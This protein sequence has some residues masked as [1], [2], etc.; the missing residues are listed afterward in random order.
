[1]C[2]V[3]TEPDAE[4]EDSEVF[5]K[6]VRKLI[7]KV[8]NNSVSGLCHELVNQ[9]KEL[10]NEFD[11]V[12]EENE[13]LRKEN[14]NL[15]EDTKFLIERNNELDFELEAQTVATRN[16]K[17]P[18]VECPKLKEQLNSIKYSFFRI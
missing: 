2:L 18:C 12:E 15:K 5:F 11:D 16:S 9:I 1:M 4:I 7:S 17:R 6:R 8:P 14:E 13:H 3:G 10:K